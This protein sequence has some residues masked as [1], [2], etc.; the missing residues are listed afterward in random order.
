MWSTRPPSRH[1]PHARACTHA[2]SQH[3]NPLITIAS[4]TIH[5]QGMKLQTVSS[6][7]RQINERVASAQ[8]HLDSLLLAVAH[9][10][11]KNSKENAGR[12]ANSPSM[13]L[14]SGALPLRALQS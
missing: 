13:P 8:K 9:W 3:R 12:S 4:E 1:E 7:V 11:V 6:Q 10:E 5:S 2:Q 14:M